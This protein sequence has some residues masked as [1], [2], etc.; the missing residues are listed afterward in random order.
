[1]NR[2]QTSLHPREPQLKLFS[3]KGL[4][5]CP[6]C[7]TLT[8]D[9][10]LECHVCSWYGKFCTDRGLIE[11]KVAELVKKCPEL[12]G[13]VEVRR[14]LMDRIKAAVWKGWVRLRL[15]LDILA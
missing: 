5:V 2:R 1:M 13:M 12:E 15:R 9:E 10:A 7:G 8:T 11:L 6:V 14:G 3:V 4:Q